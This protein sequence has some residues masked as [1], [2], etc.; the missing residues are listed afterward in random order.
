[1]R[2]Y[3]IE[4]LNYKDIASLKKV[5]DEKF[6]RPFLDEVYMVEIDESILTETQRS[7]KN[8]GPYFFTLTLGKTSLSAEFLIRSKMTMRCSCMGYS[9]DSQTLWIINLVNDIMSY[10]CVSI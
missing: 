10:A 1:M 7:H 5:L 4:N 8:C 2:L 6:G 9:D 3:V